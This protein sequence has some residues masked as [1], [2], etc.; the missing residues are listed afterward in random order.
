MNLRPAKPDDVRQ[1]LPMVEKVCALHHE[2]DRA[3][4]DYKADVID[5]YRRWLTQRSGDPQSVFVVAERE[6]RLIGFLI[7]TVERDIPIYKVERFGFIHDMW[8]EPEY[9]N[10]GVGRQMVMLAIEQFQQMGVPQIRLETAE[11]NEIAR[12]MF[13]ACG[14][15]DSSRTMLTELEP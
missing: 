3:K 5:S 12:E 15:R 7:A 1:V 13:R 10:E 14:F 8:V 9:R 2:W 4:Y 11:Q 6:S